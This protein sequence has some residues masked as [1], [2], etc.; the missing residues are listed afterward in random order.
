[1]L[2]L[3]LFTLIAAVVVFVKQVSSTSRFRQVYV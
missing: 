2:L 3:H 1:L